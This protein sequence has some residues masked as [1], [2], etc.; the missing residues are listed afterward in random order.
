M[1]KCLLQGI[2]ALSLLGLPRLRI[3]IQELLLM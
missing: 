3:P 1:S 2:P